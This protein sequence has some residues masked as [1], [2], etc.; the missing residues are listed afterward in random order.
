VSTALSEKAGGGSFAVPKPSSPAPKPPRQPT[1]PAPITPESRLLKFIFAN[2]LPGGNFEGQ[3]TLKVQLP[4]KTEWEEMVTDTVKDGT[5][6]VRSSLTGKVN[7]KLD[8]QQTFGV[9]GIQVD[10]ELLQ[11]GIP[12]PVYFTNKPIPLTGQIINVDISD[13]GDI[14]FA[15]KKDP[16]TLAGSFTSSKAYTVTDT[17]AIAIQLN[18][19][20]PNKIV[21]IQPSIQKGTSLSGTE[22]T[23][24]TYNVY[25]SPGT[26]T[27]TKP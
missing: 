21:S 10:P 22:T 8:G 24:R 1:P 16:P 20:D 17:N 14:S 12:A 23:A 11:S 6:K 13:K 3:F 9:L 18:I 25:T 19:S 2:D 15:V 5:L 27:I 26:I 4:G 7:L